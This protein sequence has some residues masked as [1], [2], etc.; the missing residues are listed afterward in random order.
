MARYPDIQYIRFS[1][2]GNAARKVEVAAPIKTMR[3]PC[4]KPQPKPAVLRVDPLALTAIVMVIVM[5]SLMLIGFLEL[6][7]AQQQTV[8]MQSYVEKLESENAELLTKFESKCKLEEIERT[9]LAL[10]M[11][12]VDQVTHISVQV[13]RQS[14]DEHPG[15]WERL[16]MFLTGLFA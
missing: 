11:V 9:A 8:I 16:T 7:A 5:A 2:D 15:A 10:G 12:P 3:L 4:V 1:T 13:P 6:K 14:T